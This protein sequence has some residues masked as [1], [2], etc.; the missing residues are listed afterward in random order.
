MRR[1]SPAFR[2]SVPRRPVS[3]ARIFEKYSKEII[4]LSDSAGRI[5]FCKLSDPQSSSRTFFPFAKDAPRLKIAR[6][7][8]ASVFK[9]M[10]ARVEANFR[11]TTRSPPLT[12]TT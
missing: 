10:V 6:V 4:W 5:L 9:K 7:Q 2:D 1:V 11:I 8:G 3:S 12:K